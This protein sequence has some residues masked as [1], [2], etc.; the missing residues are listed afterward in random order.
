MSV[1]EG[2]ATWVY[3]VRVHCFFYVPNWVIMRVLYSPYWG[4]NMYI[5]KQRI[6]KLH[7]IKCEGFSLS[8]NG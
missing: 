4:I 1:V 8:H 2:H 7:V 6:V 3:G 5:K